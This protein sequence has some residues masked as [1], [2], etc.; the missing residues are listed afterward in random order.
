[1]TTRLIHSV[2]SIYFCLFFD[3]LITLPSPS[4]RSN[5][6]NMMFFCVQ[7]EMVNVVRDFNRFCIR[8]RWAGL[9]TSL[10]WIKAINIHIHP[11]FLRFILILFK[12][13]NLPK[14][15]QQ[16]NKSSQRHYSVP[17][18]LPLRT[19]T[20]THTR[21][22]SCIYLIR[23]VRRYTQ[24]A[25]GSYGNSNTIHNDTCEYVLTDRIHTPLFSCKRFFLFCVTRK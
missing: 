8:T 2:C 16:Q 17:Y 20:H 13:K 1:M 10:F 6:V 3:H 21:L 15:Q 5:V 18:I 7:V 9:I 19:R 25:T 11:S 14:K 24:L 12:A 22:N 4:T 23:H